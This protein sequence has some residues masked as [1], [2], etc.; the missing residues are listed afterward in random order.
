MNILFT[1]FSLEHRAGSELVVVELAE[2]MQKLGHRVAAYSTRVGE[3]GDLMRS[4]GIPVIRD[5][6]ACPFVPDLIHGQHHLDAMAA[7]CA[8]PCVPAIYHCHG[9]LPWAEAPPLHPR[10]QRYVGM[11]ETLSQRI[12]IELN[13]PDSSVVTLPNW[14]DIRRFSVVREQVLVPRRALIFQGVPNPFSWHVQQLRLAF[15]RAG[16]LLDFQIPSGS[17][18][19]PEVVLPNYDIVL[20]SGRSAIEAMACGCAVLPYYPNSLLDFVSPQNFEMMR[21]QN[22]APRMHS[23]QLSRR[24]VSACLARYNPE[25][26]AR[27]T[28]L[29]REKCS[30]DVSVHNLDLLY[31]EAVS[32]AR[33][34]DESDDGPY[35]LELLAISNYLRSLQPLV[36]EY[37]RLKSAW[38]VLHD[39]PLQHLARI[40]RWLQRRLEL[41]LEKPNL[42][43]IVKSSH[44]SKSVPGD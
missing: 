18:R 14:V 38:D 34:P 9:Y 42:F 43:S 31:K 22:F 19:S 13:L 16:I 8:F 1:N 27:V 32:I 25:S 4:M 20:A 21:A 33:S 35:D 41:I 30:L 37:E 39:H 6:Q 12:R 17:K 36:R 7:L 3:V 40:L 2:G 15:A 24:S 11:C 26:T 29:V 28:S 10:I 44:K 5:P 23:P